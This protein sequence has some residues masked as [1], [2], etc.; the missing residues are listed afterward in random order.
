M[1]IPVDPN[2]LKPGVNKITVRAGNQ[3]SPT[4][5]EGNHDD[6]T[7]RNVKLVPADGTEIMDP[8]IPA[9]QRVS[10]VKISSKS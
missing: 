9:D 10:L 2:I 5:L 4:D 7:V 8:S 6:Y 3:V 1:E